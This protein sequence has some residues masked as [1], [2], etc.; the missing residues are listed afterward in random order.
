M[1]ALLIPDDI[2]AEDPRR[3]AWRANDGR[4][5][6]Q[7]IAI[8]NALHGIDRASAGMSGGIAAIAPRGRRDFGWIVGAVCPARDTGTA[9][10]LNRLDAGAA[11]SSYFRLWHIPAV[12]L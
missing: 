5:S 11:S 10:V 6:A 12:A 4:I 2:S 3:R 7:L 8:A 9:L 1:P